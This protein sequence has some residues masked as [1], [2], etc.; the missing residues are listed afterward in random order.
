[1][2]VVYVSTALIYYL[3]MFIW[4]FCCLKTHWENIQANFLPKGD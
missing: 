4:N 2:C 1:M 3:F